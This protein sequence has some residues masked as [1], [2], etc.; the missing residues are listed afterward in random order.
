M[1]TTNAKILPNHANGNQVHSSELPIIQ[2]GD[3]LLISGKL[4]HRKLKVKTTFANWIQRRI[5]KYG[6]EINQDCFPH[7]ESKKAGR[8]GH[9]SKEYLLTMDTAKELA[10]LEESDIGRAIRRYFIRF[11]KEAQQQSNTR[12]CR[13]AEAPIKSNTLSTFWQ[14]V[15]D[16]S[17]AGTIRHGQH[18]RMSATGDGILSLHLRGIYPM[19]VYAMRLRGA[20][21]IPS[22]SVL[23]TLL[24]T[25][26]GGTYRGYRK[27]RNVA[28]KDSVWVHDFAFDQIRAQYGLSLT[29][30]ML[31][32]M[33]YQPELPL[34]GGQSMVRS[35]AEM[36]LEVEDKSL[37]IRMFNH[38]T[39]KGGLI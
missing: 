26:S 7:L 27:H 23:E 1:L 25:D 18:F 4:L 9:N 17:R 11:E 2:Q 5:E 13:P 30:S 33:G 24:R 21:H 20:P 32:G 29:D 36:I 35:L 3:T 34:M 8:G 28:G 16:M 6:F 37:R 19:Y 14:L 10:M 22:K 31:S 15:T 38:L 12:L 39:Q